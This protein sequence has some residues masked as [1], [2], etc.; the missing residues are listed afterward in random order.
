[1]NIQYVLSHT[2]HLSLSAVFLLLSACTGEEASVTGLSSISFVAPSERED[3]AELEVSE[4]DGYRV[5]YGATEG[6]YTEQFF[7]KENGAGRGQVALDS[8][9]ILPGVYHA[10][11]T[12]VDT[13]GRESRVSESFQVSI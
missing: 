3:G 12:T 11:V 13:D 6:D 2:K 5:Y 9:G 7:V 1:M 4:I 10:V 8:L